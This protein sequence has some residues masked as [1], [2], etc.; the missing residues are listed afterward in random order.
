MKSS[1]MLVGLFATTTLLAVASDRPDPRGRG[2]VVSL[3]TLTVTGG[4]ASCAWDH[5]ATTFDPTE[6]IPEVGGKIDNETGGPRDAI[7]FEIRKKGRDGGETLPLIEGGK[8]GGKPFTAK[9]P[10]RSCT[11][12]LGGDSRPPAFQYGGTLAFELDLW[13]PDRSEASAPERYALR[14]TLG[15][16]PPRVLSASAGK[17]PFDVAEKLRFTRL[18]P[19]GSTEVATVGH[20]GILVRVANG[21]KGTQ[22]ENLLLSLDGRL[23]FPRDSDLHLKSAYLTTPDGRRLL[24][25]D[26]PGSEPNAF[27]LVDLKLHPGGEALLWLRFSGTPEEATRVALRAHFD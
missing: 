1:A 19:R 24:D 25:V 11:L 26:S 20:D 18:S 8:I 13:P 9:E 5:A 16:S 27:S 6:G 23:S 4:S 2:Q 12:L 17:R 7:T 22:S 3:G 21:E 15:T 10:A 14:I